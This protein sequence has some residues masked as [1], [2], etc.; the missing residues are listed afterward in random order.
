M[1]DKS[2]QERDQR[3]LDAL[4]VSQLR[5]HQETGEVDIEKLPR[6]TSEE[7]AALD[8][9][10][11]DFM[12]RLIA[13]ELI[14]EDK[15]TEE[16]EDEELLC[17]GGMGFGLNRAEEIDEKTEEALEKKRKEILDRLKKK[18]GSNVQPDS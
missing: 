5:R 7:K 4:I 15:K 17:A 11:P 14:P 16:V 9:L 2:K 6:L 8:S 1:T 12:D 3:A 10:G 13:G 18:D